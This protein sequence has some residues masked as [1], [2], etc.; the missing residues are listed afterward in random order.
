MLLRP[1]TLLILAGLSFLAA[2]GTGLRIFF[3]LSYL[4]PG[5][6]A[7]A[8][9]WAWLNLRGL[10]VERETLTPRATVGEY[11]RERITLRNR[12]FLPKLWVELYDES[13]LPER[14]P[15]FVASLA[16]GE[17]GR[18]TARTRCTRRGR[19]RL[20]PATLISGDP[21]G[22]VR[23]R[24]S[25]PATAEILVYP[26]AVDLPEFRLPGAE[27]PGGQATRA[28]SFQLTPNVA[29][30]REYAPG[31]SMNRIHWRSTAR[32]GQLMVKEFELDPSADVYLVLDMQER[33]VVCDTRLARPHRPEDA[34][35]S[36]PWWARQPAAP[37]APELES[38]EEHAVMAAAS[39]ARALLAQN[40]AVGL[41]AWGQH[42]ELIPAEREARQ[43][44]KILE[45]LAVL[46]AEGAHALAEV[47]V[48]E[49]QRFGRNCTLVVISASVDERWVSALQQHL[50]RGVRAVV[51][52]VDP[53]SYGGW[54]D[55]EPVLRRL[56]ELRVPV[57]RLR[58]GQPLPDALREPL[59]M[60]RQELRGM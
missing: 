12:W 7:L 17:I 1:L 45:A 20:G 36:A 56:A 46:R 50:Y 49:S 47:L 38:T 26:R 23:L 32:L 22:I 9:L 16:G 54:Q 11:A 21:F 3:H 33:T 27:L 60:E 31:D 52:F 25:A 42:R 53:R 24:R 44:F 10:V 6:L 29:T 40:R 5:L 51:L 18:W 14:G 2:Q 8:M 34:R 59:G 13:E 37:P 48:A 41:V 57:Y 58:Q 4:L 30:V 15:G 35:D 55:P 19:F 39:L 43:L 28:R